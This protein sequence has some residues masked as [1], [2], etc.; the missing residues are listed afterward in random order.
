MLETIRAYGL[1][2]LAATGRLPEART[3]YTRCFLDQAER[4][5]PHLRG[6]GQ[7]P[8]IAR[9]SAER[10]NLLTALRFAVEAGDAETAVRLGAALG[11]FWTIHGDHAEAANRLRGA[12]AVPGPVPEQIRLEAVASFLISSMLA[13]DL[14]D[15][16]AVAGP[17]RGSGPTAALVRALLAL[18][19]GEFG[20]GLSTLDGY[21][22][23]PDPWTR[24][25]LWLVR[26]FLL[27]TEG[28]SHNGRQALGTA[29]EGFRVAGE[30]WGLALSLMSLA[31]TA[32]SAG[33]F[34]E[35]VAALDETMTLLRVLGTDADQRI[36]AAMVRIDAGDVTAARADLLDVLDQAPSI[37]HI[38][39]ARLTLADLARYDGDLREAAHQLALAGVDGDPAYRVLYSAGA[40]RHAVATGDLDAAARHL[41][42]AYALAV[43]MPDLPMVA[44]VGVGV[45]DLLR[46]SGRPER[47][48]RILGA[49]HALSGG[50]SARNPD[51]LRLTRDLPALLGPDDYRTAYDGGR[52]LGRDAALGL[53]RDS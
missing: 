47:A 40:G 6:S 7:L 15:A 17:V 21:L 48:A 43:T 9:L 14:A 52:R 42:Q 30:R 41:G 34:D 44:M 31:S 13:G 2:R 28:D 8:W 35:A 26:A 37:R 24:A 50:P 33:D 12:L 3:A 27:G 36:W 51:V 22:T 11:Q 20:A 32:L 1:E 16:A 39:L 49:A 4:A 25:M 19:G 53:I 46:H 23:H 29:V 45:A 18:V 38:A 10:D 5:A